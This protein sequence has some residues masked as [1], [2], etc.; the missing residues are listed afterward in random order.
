MMPDMKTTLHGFEQNAIFEIVVK[1]VSGGDVVESS[2]VRPPLYFQGI[3]QPIHP[4]ELLVK[5]EGERNFKWWRLITD[6][7]LQN[8]WII[9]DAKGTK[10]RVMTS[11][12]W[13]ISGYVAYDLTEGPAYE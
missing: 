7:K 8:D 2:K 4:K 1:T 11:S 13:G 10:Y 3:F 9:K 5:P 6:M 12:D